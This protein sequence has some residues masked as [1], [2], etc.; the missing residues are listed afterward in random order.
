MRAFS[1][2]RRIIPHSSLIGGPTHG[3]PISG[4]L[5][6]VWVAA[7][8]LCLFPS[9]CPAQDTSPELDSVFRLFEEGNR[10]LAEGDF[11][12]AIEKYSLAL[13][14]NALNEKDRAAIRLARAQAYVAVN[15]LGA[16]GRELSQALRS[17]GLDGAT[18]STA[19][20]IRGQVGLKKKLYNLA[21]QDFTDSI[22]IRHNDYD[23][24]AA[25]YASRGLTFLNMGKTHKAISDLNQALDLNDSLGYAYACRAMARLKINELEAA[26]RDCNAALRLEPYGETAEL[27]NKVIR[28]LATPSSAKSTLSS[29]SVPMAD[30][31]HIY[32]RMKF[33][34]TGSQHRFMVDTG[35]TTTVI[36]KEILNKIRKHTRVER[37]GK[38]RVITADGSRHL[39]TRYRVEDAYIFHLP[40]GE[41]EALVF[42]R[43]SAKVMQVLGVKA[44]RDISIRIDSHEKKA[45][46]A[47]MRNLMGR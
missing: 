32:V 38:G 9:A 11:T 13:Q 20:W 45:R 2:L 15:R 36:K 21:L 16:A 4:P 25:T 33:G 29:V 14:S 18:R 10:R 19:L 46:I 23:L 22:K 31:G 42:D 7:L 44:L 6:L 1:K 12:M 37:I 28:K 47:L 39:V 43:K 5:I 40:I 3:L 26:R 35:A 27:A 8:I 30:D 34:R 17:P 24:R 41:I